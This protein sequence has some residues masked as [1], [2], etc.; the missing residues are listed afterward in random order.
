M[1]HFKKLQKLLRIALFIVAA[2]LTV[3]MARAMTLLYHALSA[4]G[5]L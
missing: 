3:F 5:A 1:K 4:E 2:I